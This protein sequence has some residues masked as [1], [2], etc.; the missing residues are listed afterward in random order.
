MKKTIIEVYETRDYDKFKRLQGNREISHAKKIIKSIQKVGYILNPIIVNE[1]W[2]IID[3]QNRFEALKTLNMP[4]HYYV[5][6][7]TD[8]ETAISLNLGQENWKP[9]DYIKSYADDGKKSYQL[10]LKFINEYNIG[11]QEAYGLL[12]NQI[13]SGGVRTQ[14]VS[15]G[16]FVTTEKEYN[17]AK[18]NM[19]TLKTVEKAI[20]LIEGS[21]R[22]MITGLA[23]CMNID[24]CDKKRLLSE[25]SS[26]CTLIPP[27]ASAETFL[28]EI[29]KI[30]N[31]NLKDKKKI[32]DFDTIYRHI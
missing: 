12:K 29:S 7:G 13:T 15:N 3:G 19:E 8:R 1:K 30:Y 22:I 16:D 5:V 14:M 2:E 32:I 23:W 28:R 18:A 27:V 11:V 4:I 25:F 10:L 6:E 17:Q 21:R 24:G 31:R 26:K 20:K 9:M